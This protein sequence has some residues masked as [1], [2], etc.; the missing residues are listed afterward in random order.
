MTRLWRI[1]LV[2]VSLMLATNGFAN[3]IEES[4]L[5]FRWSLEETQLSSG[6]SA[7]ALTS[8]DYLD[9]RADHSFDLIVVQ[10]SVFQSGTWALKGDSLHLFYE[11]LPVETSIDSL[12]YLVKD[13]SASLLLFHEG[14]EV[15]RQSIDGLSS[16]RRQAVFAVAKDDRGNVRLASSAEQ[17]LL[18][19]R[20]ELVKEGFSISSVLRALMGI[21]VLLGICWLFSTNRQKIDWNLV[22]IGMG[23]QLIFALLVLKAP[24]VSDAFGWM[25]GGFVT[26]LS[27]TLDGSRFLFD[28]LVD[29][30]TSGYIFAFQ[31]LPIIVFFSAV[32]SILY[33]L[34]VLQ[35]IVY[36]FAWLLSKFMRL[37]G[38]ESLAAAGNIFLGQTESPLLIK[39][40]LPKMT[41]SEVMALMT[42]GMATIAGSVF[43]AYIGYLGGDSI[44]EQTLFATHLL[45]AS[46]MSA[47]AALVAAKMLVPETEEVLKD[48]RVPKDKIGSNILDAIANGTTEGLK[49]AI[50]V[51]VMLLVFLALIKMVNY[52][53][54]DMIGA[55]TGLND[56]VVQATDGKFQAFGLEYIFG[57]VF[58]PLA[59]LMGVPAE[60]MLLVGQLLGEKT[61]ANEF[62]AYESLGNMKNT[63]ALTHY[64]SLI[65]STY[66]LCGFA[67][68]SSIGIQIGGISAL[69][70][71]QRQL[72]SELGLRALLGGTVAAFLT[73]VLAGLLAA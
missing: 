59:W 42:G 47:P 40:Y 23:L 4:D 49:L 20:A 41:R 48:L 60:D 52:F 16:Q 5:V 19:G 29:I 51:G 10:D 73:A 31:V 54:G 24:G 30:P 72:L 34:G 69:A 64:K 36:G 58:S 22:G 18:G 13:N 63:G 32:T 44:E 8:G 27:F 35:K 3:P 15:A 11:L 7:Y 61:V 6:E 38:A 57:L 2:S 68:F 66:A 50:N 17:W 33:Y 26:F 37:S 67:N 45:T 65:I 21:L 70:P 55:S 39:P 53:L 71:N 28:S 25:A 56:W 12:A 14:R 43:G 9:M 46:I 62:V 1:L